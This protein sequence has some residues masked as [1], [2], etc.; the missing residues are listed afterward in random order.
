MRAHCIHEGKGGGRGTCC[1]DAVAAAG[2]ASGLGS[3]KASVG[4]A[5]SSWKRIAIQRIVREAHLPAN[6]VQERRHN[7]IGS[8]C[9][10]Q[11]RKVLGRNQLRVGI[12]GGT[13]REFELAS[14]SSRG[15]KEH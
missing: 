13:V 8:R 3:R 2:V 5:V 6:G 14:F 15:V 7:E 10:S 11:V 1:N 9:S 4:N 12:G